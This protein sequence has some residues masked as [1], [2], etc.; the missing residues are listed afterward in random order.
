[1]NT[2][3]LKYQIALTLIPGVGDVL[4]KNLISYC[5]SA[6]EVFKQKKAQLFK[7]PDIG[8]VIAESI[9]KFNSFKRAEEEIKFIEK[10]KIQPLFYLDKTYPERLKQCYDSPP[11][12]YYKGNVELNQT[13]IL[14][15]VGTRKASDYGKAITEEI[16][17]GLSQEGILIISGLAYGIDIYAHKAALKNNLNTIGVVGHGLD[18][19]YPAIHK[20]VAEKMINQGGILTEFMSKTKMSPENF[21][22]RN[23]IVA[24]I[25]DAV[26]IVEAAEKGGALIT[27]EIANSY[28]RDVFA[29]PGRSIDTVS[30]GCNYLIKSNK[31]ALVESHAIP[32]YCYEC[33]CQ[34]TECSVF[35]TAFQSSESLLSNYNTVQKM[36]ITGRF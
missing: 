14:A 2:E 35:E 23:R 9:V 16:I 11:L 4:A 1:M 7:I 26:L 31:A 13:K 5:G 32:P 25:S 29:I 8:P 6:E 24:G 19:I 28:N 18:T 12:L 27:A 22:A 3:T 15:I 17:S 10:Y 30:R 20:P 21:P 36:E 33:I 34:L